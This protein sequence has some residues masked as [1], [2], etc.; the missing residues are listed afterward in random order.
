MGCNEIPEKTSRG[1]L[2]PTTVSAQ[3]NMVGGGSPAEHLQARSSYMVLCNKG[4]KE[5]SINDM[6]G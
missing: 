1:K 6:M 2:A 4:Y 5:G 3:R